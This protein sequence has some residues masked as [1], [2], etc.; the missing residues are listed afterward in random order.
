MRAAVERGFN[1]LISGPR[2]GG[3]TSMLRQLQLEL[4]DS[5][6]DRSPAF[7]DAAAAQT[8][9][10]LVEHVREAMRGRPSSRRTLAEQAAFS[11]SLFTQQPPGAASTYLVRLVRELGDESPRTVLL[12]ASGAGTAV[13]QLFGRL[14]DELWQLDHRWVV[15]IE[16]EELGTVMRPPAD[17]VFDVEISLRGMS[18]DEL[19]EMLKRR[20]TTLSDRSLREIAG[21]SRGSPRAA[22]QAARQ[23]IIGGRKPRDVLAEHAWRQTESSKLGRPHS[24][25]MAELENLGAASASDKELLDRMGWTRERAAQVLSQLESA[26]LVISSIERQARGRPRKIFRPAERS[27]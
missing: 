15:A 22:M 17:A 10:G 6:L 16:A 3:K 14:R 19:V 27:A 8:P 25:L 1:V 5:E 9:L 11:T 4:R 2:G 21:A 24:M 13:Y 7:V 23:A 26:G 18:D 12:D 20:E